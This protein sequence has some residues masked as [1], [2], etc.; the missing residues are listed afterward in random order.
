MY[1]AF[2]WVGTTLSCIDLLKRFARCLAN[3]GAPNL[4]Y[5]TGSLS[6]PVAVG[7]SRS[8]ILKT[9]YSLNGVVHKYR[10]GH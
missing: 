7:F 3:T 1:A 4:R 2:H 8:S 9:S 5:H 6:S 10:D